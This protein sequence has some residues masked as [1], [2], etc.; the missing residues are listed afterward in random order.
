MYLPQFCALVATITP[1][2][3]LYCRSNEVTARL[4]TKCNQ[5]AICLAYL[6]SML[7][8]LS[9]WQYFSVNICLGPN[10]DRYLVTGLHTVNDIYCSCCQQILGWRYVSTNIIGLSCDNELSYFHWIML[11]SRHSSEITFLLKRK[12]NSLQQ[13]VEMRTKLKKYLS[14]LQK[15]LNIKWAAMHNK[16]KLMLY[17][18]LNCYMHISVFLKPFR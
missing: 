1:K 5:A 2:E 18:F 14:F 6:F 8:K 3:G 13:F 16:W 12:K 11:G 10:E 9:F 15:A 17:S 4:W 7:L